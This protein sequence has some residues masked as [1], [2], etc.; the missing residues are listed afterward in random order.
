M[1]DMALATPVS[2]AR[3]EDRR[4]MRP[5]H[6]R[7]PPRRVPNAQ[8]RARQY[9]TIEEVDKVIDAAARNR[10]GSRDALMIRLAYRHGLTS[11]E[12]IDLQWSDIDLDAQTL[13]FVRE[14][15]RT[16][17]TFH[18]GTDEV[19]LLRELQ[20]NPSQ[21]R[22]LVFL[23]ERRGAFTKAGFA[24]MVKRAGRSAKLAIDIHPLILRRSRGLALVQEGADAAALQAVFGYANRQKAIRL[25]KA[26]LAQ[27]TT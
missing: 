16:L 7:R 12:L 22:R 2:D 21:S 25:L 6:C 27:L 10:W 18:L 1:S 4:D 26:A 8:L 5:S 17:V 14:R 11:A 24:R 13:T 23:S 15:S 20:S 9:L 19:T 3:V